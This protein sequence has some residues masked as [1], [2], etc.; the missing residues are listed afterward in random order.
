MIIVAATDFSTRSHRALRQAGLLARSRRAELHL[1]HVVDEDQPADLVRMEER[2]AQRVLVEQIGSMPELHDARCYPTVVKGHPFDGILRAAAAVGADLI[3]MGGH[4]KQFLRDIF[5]GTTI[6]RVIRGGK[7]PVLMVNNEAQRRYER[8]LVPIDMSETS[9]EAIR[10]GLSTG[11]LE[12]D[13]A[14]LLHAFSPMAK[15]RL[16]SSGASSAVITGY[17]ESERHRAMEEL[18]SFLVTNEFGTRRWSLRVGEGGPMQI[19]TRAV[20]EKRPDMLVMGTHGRSGLLRALIGS[21]TEE[22]L[23]SLN[24]DVLVVPPPASPK[25][26]MAK[27]AVASELKA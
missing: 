14:T 11:L 24:V 8:V 13:G 17:V 5:T 12:E 10:I 19:I 22:V 3:V 4:R 25:L 7:Y 20:E 1:V 21:V 27:E 9:A 18:T 6:E 16:I 23:R 15:T 26:G 2:E